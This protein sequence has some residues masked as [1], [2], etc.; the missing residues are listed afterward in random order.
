LISITSSVERKET[1]IKKR[2]ISI[3]DANRIEIDE[4]LSCDYYYET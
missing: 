3:K 4:R 1:D 2:E